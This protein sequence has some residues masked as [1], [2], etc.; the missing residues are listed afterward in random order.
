MIFNVWIINKSGGLA[1]QRTI[2][3]FHPKLTSNDYLV[4]AST[5]QSVHAISSRVGPG[6]G[7]VEVIEWGGEHPY[8]V[9]CLQSGTGV[10][11]LVTAEAGRNCEG[12]LR[13]IYEIY[14]DFVLKNP[15]HTME[16]P[17]RCELFDFTLLKAVK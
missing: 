3:E 12:L 1:Y 2:T 10:K 13:K 14:A 15:F 6:G 5:F 11:I 8:T 9:N 4:I 16:M 7:G 17:I